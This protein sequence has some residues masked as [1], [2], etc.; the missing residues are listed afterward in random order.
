MASFLLMR[1]RW[2]LPWWLLTKYQLPFY[3]C[4]CAESRLAFHALYFRVCRCRFIRAAARRIGEPI[5]SVIMVTNS[6]SRTVFQ[7]AE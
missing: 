7:A 1:P 4:M 5:I 2:V 6:V 3:L